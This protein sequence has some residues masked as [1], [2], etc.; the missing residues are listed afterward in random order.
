MGKESDGDASSATPAR[1]KR[2]TLKRAAHVGA[3]LFENRDLLLE[4]LERLRARG[5]I[6][7]A[8]EAR[9]VASWQ[10]GTAEARQRLA[11]IIARLEGADLAGLAARF[12][13]QRESLRRDG[14]QLADEA[15]RLLSSYANE[16]G[17]A[18]DAQKILEL[19]KAEGKAAAAEGNKAVNAY[20]QEGEQL[21]EKYKVEG[22][23][24][25]SKYRGELQDFLDRNRPSIDA[26]ER[27]GTQIAGAAR[28]LAGSLKYAGR[29][30]ADELVKRGRKVLLEA[31]TEAWE[32]AALDWSAQTLPQVERSA[33]SILTWAG[34]FFVAVALLFG[35]SLY[36]P[37]RAYALALAGLVSFALALV[38][39]QAAW[40]LRRVSTDATER[41][42]KW[43]A[44]SSNERRA[45]V[46]AKWKARK[47]ASERA[48]AGEPAD[49][50]IPPPSQ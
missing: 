48:A 27:A 7:S 25:V 31:D 34:L 44:M 46:V 3:A 20:R 49:A 50:P 32:Q 39:F 21:V 26:V 37:I 41:L 29:E 15:K 16:G 17:L 40:R 19:Y 8:D 9:A 47:E 38:V 10:E 4:A 13:S 33:R 43:A 18:R 2:K 12:Q 30:A 23:A 11:S 14:A 5:A 6:S 1:K 22:E 36:E 35:S 42:E 24:L 45:V 28:E